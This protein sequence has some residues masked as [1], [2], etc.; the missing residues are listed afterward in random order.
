MTYR[1]K[2]EELSEEFAT[3][4]TGRTA[5]AAFE[6]LIGDVIRLCFF[7]SLHNI[8]SKVRSVDGTVIR[9]WIASNRAPA[10]FWAIIR[11]KY[12]ATQI[13]WEC[14]NYADL[15][16]DDFHQAMYY[17]NEQSGRFLIMVCRAQEPVSH[18]ILNHLKRVFTQTK[19]IVLVLRES[20]IKTFLRQALNGK[21]SEQHLQD[22]FDNA[23]RLIS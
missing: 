19:G 12:N 22:L 1:S 9:D 10:G 4:P 16:A 8:E 21:R 3:M 6:T 5:S 15:K 18:Q 20:D 14:K 11:D 13:I 7:R 17:M 23:E 2:L